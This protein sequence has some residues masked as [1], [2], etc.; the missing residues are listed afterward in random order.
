MCKQYLSEDC[1]GISACLSGRAYMAYQRR[2]THSPLL[3][4]FKAS[5][6]C[7]KKFAS[8]YYGIAPKNM[9]WPKKTSLMKRKQL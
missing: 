5:Q 6:K 1:S 4:Y 8:A 3:H 9:T 2:C 7:S